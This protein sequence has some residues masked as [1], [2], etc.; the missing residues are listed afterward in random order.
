M[1]E[2]YT[3]EKMIEALE[4]RDSDVLVQIEKSYGA[5]MRRIADNLSLNANDTEECINDAVL[6]V[7]NTIPP[8]KPESIRSYVCMLMRRTV[9]DR[10]RYNAAE[11]RGNTVYLEVSDELEECTD[12][13]NM[14]VDE[15]CITAAINRFLEK[16]KPQ[17][18]EIFIR[19]FYEFESSKSIASDLL[20][21]TNTVDKRLSR[22]RGDL[23]KILTEWGY[24]N[25]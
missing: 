11:K 9:I 17:N 10:I 2:L 21:S 5:L 7:W 1:K 13:E 14:V 19:R 18:R 6:E 22:M 15:M 16:Q 4:R 12:V 23:K 20:I 25:G 3:T 24:E 8:A